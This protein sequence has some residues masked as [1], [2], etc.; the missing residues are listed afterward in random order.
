MTPVSEPPLSIASDGDA[1]E[2]LYWGAFASSMFPSYEAFWVENVAPLTYR[3]TVRKN[4]RFRTDG[5]LAAAGFGDED[6]AIAQ[7]H[8]T[9]LL[10]IGRVWQ[11]LHEALTFTTN[12]ARAGL[13]FDP[14]HFFVSFA[15]LSGASDVADELL[16]RRRTR[17]S[18]EYPAWDERAGSRARRA[19]RDSHPDVLKDI[20]AYRHRLVHG[21]VVPQ[22]YARVFGLGTGTYFGEQLMY[23]KLDKVD[24]HLDWRP[25]VAPGLGSLDA[26]LPEFERAH[27]LV[28]DAWGRVVDYAESSWQA[29]LL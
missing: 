22:L 9:F 25:A 27:L 24:N 15:R 7:L 19:W 20:R 29:H 10:H 11:L 26:L 2:Q 1:W 4:I 12:D 6:V 5:E 14:N 16:E 13:S 8:Y 28:R 17:G 21:R 18:G 3:G 23:P